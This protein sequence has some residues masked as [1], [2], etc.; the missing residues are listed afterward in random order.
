MCSSETGRGEDV[1]NEVTN[2]VP[3]TGYGIKK[4]HYLRKERLKYVPI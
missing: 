2:I 4:E 1:V 3:A